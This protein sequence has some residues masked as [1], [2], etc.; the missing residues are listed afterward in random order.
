VQ[1][2][3]GCERNIVYHVGGAAFAAEINEFFQS[4]GI[5]IIQGFGLTEFFPVCVASAM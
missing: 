1:L 4:I 2:K 5:N 3:L